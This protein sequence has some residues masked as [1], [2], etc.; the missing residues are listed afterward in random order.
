M[1]H[2][3]LHDASFTLALGE[4]R[5]GW[6]SDADVRLPDNDHA[7]SA[8]AVITLSADGKAAVR[9]GTGDD[10]V[11]VNGV[12]VGREAAPLLHGDR[13]TIHGCELRFA[14]EAMSGATGE[15]PAFSPTHVA[16][17]SVGVLEARSGGRLMSMIDGREYRLGESPLRIGRDASCD[18]VVA[19]PKVSR[20]H[21]RIDALPNGGGD[22]I[23]D[24]SRHGVFVNDGRVRDRVALGR[25]DTIQIGDE[26]FRFHADAAPSLAPRSLNEVPSLQST[27][28]TPRAKGPARGTLTPAGVSEV[29][30]TRAGT[31]ASLTI[32]NPG[33]SRGTRFD[34]IA[35][36]SHVGRGAYNDVAVLD[37]SVSDSH[38]KIQRRD[39]SWWVVD[40]DS[41]NG[42]Y[43][44]GTRVVG[45][46]PLTSGSDVRFG[47]VKM[48]F[49]TVGDAQRA[50]GATRVIVGLRAPDPQRAAPRVT[51]AQQAI[52]QGAANDSTS[53]RPMAVWLALAALA[54]ILVYLVLQG[55]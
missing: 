28:A 8:I 39:N 11:V 34:L 7:R 27:G 30:P 53:R 5:V 41:T 29:S 22:E 38:A 13:L 54:A 37:E 35:P 10:R 2:L 48:S 9:S 45:E 1:P 42:T 6:G 25:G 21:A 47:G 12:P 16:V 55:R 3:Q 18:I 50:D 15:M 43:V 20:H 26:S 14:D 32:L 33:P 46:A 36:L 51:S 19:S 52:D 49:V 4:T 24:Q 31:L 40:I 17:P 23:V 44:N